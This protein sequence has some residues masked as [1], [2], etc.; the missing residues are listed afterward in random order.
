MWHIQ[1]KGSHTST[2]VSLINAAAVQFQH[3]CELTL[4][5]TCPVKKPV[6]PR[7]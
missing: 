6:L 4:D 1:L 2:A 3:Y 7:W 5:P